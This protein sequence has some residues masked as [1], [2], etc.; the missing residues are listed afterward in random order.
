MTAENTAGHNE[1]SEI[2]ITKP[3]I[4]PQCL[5]PPSGSLSPVKVSIPPSGSLSP[6]KVS[7]PPSGSLAEDPEDGQRFLK[8]PNHPDL[9]CILKIALLVQG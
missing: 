7:I 1:N 6:V 8:K 5:Y 3:S 2:A 4:S 9:R